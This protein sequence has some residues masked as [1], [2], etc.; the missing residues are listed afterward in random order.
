MFQKMQQSQNQWLF[1]QE[2]LNLHGGHVHVIGGERKRTKPL[3]DQLP[4]S[5]DVQKKGSQISFER[6]LRSIPKLDP[7]HR[8]LDW[9]MSQ[10]NEPM[11]I[12]VT[13]KLKLSLIQPTFN[14]WHYTLQNFWVLS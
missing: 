12:I 2:Q 13:I 3:A 10:Q 9:V 11:V 1:T 5:R 6:F 14:S 8:T 7:V 4:V